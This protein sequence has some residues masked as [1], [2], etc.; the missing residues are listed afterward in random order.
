MTWIWNHYEKHTK[1]V[2][3]EDWEGRTLPE[4]PWDTPVYYNPDGGRDY[5]S[6]ETCYGV[7]DEY[8]PL[9]AIT[10]GDL[11]GE[12]YGH[13]DMCPYCVPPEK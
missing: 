6:Q 2:I 5:H 4:I 3:W 1:I 7:R 12:T 10:Y 11:F 9:T 13:L 8:E